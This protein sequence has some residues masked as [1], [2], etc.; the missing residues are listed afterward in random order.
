AISLPSDLSDD[1]FLF[2]FF[3]SGAQPRRPPIQ[4][5]CP[6][7]PCQCKTSI[8]RHNL[9]SSFMIAFK[10]AGRGQKQAPDAAGFHDRPVFVKIK[11]TL[12]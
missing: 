2:L 7:L 4:Y 1:A 8:S 9:L 11:S 5:A 6:D 3:P 12:R 10:S